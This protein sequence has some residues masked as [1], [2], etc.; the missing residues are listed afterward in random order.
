MMMTLTSFEA[1]K[2]PKKEDS[3]YELASI[4]KPN[5]SS[6]SSVYTPP[7][8]PTPADPTDSCE[9]LFLS[10]KISL[11]DC[12]GEIV[13]CKTGTEPPLA[14]TGEDNMGK[15][16]Q[17]ATDLDDFNPTHLSTLQP[18]AAVLWHKNQVEAD[19]KHENSKKKHS[20]LSDIPVKSAPEEISVAP[21]D[22]LSVPLPLRRLVLKNQFN[23]SAR[24]KKSP[25][26]R[27]RPTRLRN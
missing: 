10:P 2:T 4:C 14:R 18:D 13:L 8:P 26:R 27:T 16:Q 17:K 7:N 25:A 20:L 19:M 22:N 3:M 23:Q 24:V 1:R 15:S 12:K 21:V 5:S 6:P 11:I 9:S